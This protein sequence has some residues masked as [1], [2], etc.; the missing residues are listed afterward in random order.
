MFVSR[1]RTR[2]QS[3]AY[4]SP[5]LFFM[6]CGVTSGLSSGFIENPWI[7]GGEAPDKPID[8]AVLSRMKQFRAMNKLKKL[9]LKVIAETLSEEE[10]K[11]LKTMFANMDTNKSG[12]ITYEELKTW[13]TRLG[14]K[15]SETEVK[16]LMEA[17]YV[18]STSSSCGVPKPLPTSSVEAA[19][20]HSRVCV[21]VPAA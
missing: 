4:A 3:T 16:Q 18:C 13:L 9:V 5:V 11:G 10:I 8:S 21:F 6:S 15:L 7:K 20:S 17:R 19:W 14:S 2:S 1:G 12:T